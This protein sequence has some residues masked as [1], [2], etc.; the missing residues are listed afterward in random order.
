MLGRIGVGGMGVVYSGYDDELDRRVAIKLLRDSL[1]KFAEVDGPRLMREAQALARLSH[2]NVVQVYEVGRHDGHSFV[3]M[4][5]V[6]GKTLQTWLRERP[7][8][9][10]WRE[11]LEVYV[12]AGRG[13]AAAHDVGLVHRDFKPS[14]VMLGDDGRVRVL[15]FGLVSSLAAEGD[16]GANASQRSPATATRPYALATPLTMTGAVLGTPAYMAPEQLGG[17]R[18]D[19]R[20]DQFSYCVALFEALY[21][22]R[23]HVGA[24]IWDVLEASERGWIR[25]PPAGARVPAWLHAAVLRG[26]APDP[27]G[28]WPSM[29]ALLEELDRDRRGPV[30]RHFGLVLGGLGLALGVWARPL[31]PTPVE[32]C[33]QET[34]VDPFAQSSVEAR[35]RSLAPAVH[36]RL[37]RLVDGWRTARFDLCLRHRGGSLSAAAY[38]RGLECLT[39]YRAVLVRVG[40]SLAAGA[41]L[42]H[43]SG[44]AACSAPENLL[45]ESG[46]AGASH[47]EQTARIG[48]K[49]AAAQA[50]LILGHHRDSEALAARA[51]VDARRLADGP[52][53]AA[54]LY[55]LARAQESG[56]QAAATED[57]LAEAADLAAKHGLDE[58]AADVALHQLRVTWR[59]G[60]G[61][62]EG[63]VRF[64]NLRSHLARL[65]AGGDLREADAHGYLGD[66]ALDAR[67]YATA[68]VEFE[69]ALVGHASADPFLSTR[70]LIGLGRALT[71]ERQFAAARVRFVAALRII[72]SELGLDHVRVV[73]PLLNLG[74]SHIEEQHYELAEAPI[75]RALAI[76]DARPG[77]SL[78]PAAHYDAAR[79]AEA[80]GDFARAREH[81]EVARAALRAPGLVDERR[82]YLGRVLDQVG[83]MNYQ[84]GEFRAALAPYVELLLAPEGHALDDA[85]V[86]SVAY[87]N[88]AEIAYLA[89]ADELA[90][91]F[92]AAAR[93]F[94]ARLEPS[95]A[96]SLDVD[97]ALAVGP[98]LRRQGRAAEA[99]AVL[100]AA[101]AA[102]GPGDQAS[103]PRAA[104]LH[105][106]LFAAL[107]AD[108]PAHAR[109]HALRARA[110]L[111]AH[112]PP[113]RERIAALS[114]WLHAH[115]S[116][117]R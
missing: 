31:P 93:P 6:R 18:C 40:E 53:L 108:A 12:P 111:S 34:A 8:P 95:D 16:D 30:R 36:A 67:D 76:L 13:L 1:E 71:A 101:L 69:R 86:L 60:G 20:T 79:I 100:Q 59:L 58:L 9:R 17:R 91:R 50:A 112:D 102:W 106:Q 88:A 42:S 74:E 44:L 11:V 98:A 117:A 113:P 66:L 77:S 65:D 94:V 21:G 115:P 96:R 22:V 41:D 24:T 5:Y 38:R 26:L 4:E 28:R 45:R 56:P 72:E 19:A 29:R 15:D 97:L 82:I 114:A 99:A 83:R 57:T 61:M 49:L 68:R 62:R 78:V 107:R 32:Q 116:E 10:P 87:A 75:L 103:E 81:A 80:R 37:A 109:A 92:A 85:P 39:S 3:A 55:H 90:L 27:A 70:A 64:N 14:N 84:A 35:T 110:L 43:L 89:G 25:R 7:P 51:V 52:T 33:E 23:P 105:E 2:P 104:G 63:R 47:R 46:E 48:E 54:A 73:Q